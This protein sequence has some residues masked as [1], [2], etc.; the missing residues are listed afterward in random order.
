MTTT[1][2]LAA[3]DDICPKCGNDDKAMI[4]GN[5]VN[6]RVLTWHCIWCKHT[7]KRLAIHKDET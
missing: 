1:H 5:V 3:T 4:G 2:R 6:D 7:W